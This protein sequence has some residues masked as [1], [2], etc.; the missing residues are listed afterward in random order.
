VEQYTLEDIK[1]QKKQK[2]A[3]AR[4]EAEMAGV[5]LEDGTIIATDRESQAALANAALI[6]KDNPDYTINWKAKNGWITL[7][8]Q[9]IIELV[10][11]VREHVQTCF[12]K[13]KA[14]NDAIDNATTIEELNSISWNNT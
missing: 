11:I 7:N 9:Q 3:Q 13:E 12:D 8:A 2:I 1:N 10:T 5:T 14:L 4:Y 6:A